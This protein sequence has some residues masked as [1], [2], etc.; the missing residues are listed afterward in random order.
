MGLIYE[1]LTEQILA[2]CM[3]VHNHLGCG[4][5]EAVYAEAL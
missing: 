1:D 5:L 3:E 4:L 2:A